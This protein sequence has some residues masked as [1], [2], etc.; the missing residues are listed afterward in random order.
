MVKSPL[1]P[2]DEIV[3]LLPEELAPL[4]LR[5]L[6]QIGQNS[7]DRGRL[8]MGNYCNHFDADIHGPARTHQERENTR[9]SLAEAWSLL[10]TLGLLARDTNQNGEW[11]FVTRR[12]HE[13]AKSRETFE[14]GRRAALFPPDVLHVDLRGAAYDALIRGNFQQAVAEAFRVVEVR[15][16]NA[17]KREGVGASL[18]RSAF[19]E[20]TGPLRSDAPD[21]GERQALPHLFAGAFGWVRNPA[22]HRDVSMDDVNNALEQLMLASLLLRITDERI[23]SGPTGGPTHPTC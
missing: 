19:H 12:G 23:S 17:S 4:I 13:A 14:R 8:H 22:S 15:V 16:R 10:E 7:M 21:K 9:H 1:P 5:D 6:A 3:S 20:D 18:M 11:V 2:P